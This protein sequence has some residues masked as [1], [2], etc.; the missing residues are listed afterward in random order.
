MKVKV[1]LI[2]DYPPPYGGISVHVKQL[3]DFLVEKGVERRVLD[4][5]PGTAPKEGAVRVTGYFSFLRRLVS[6]SFQGF[7]P[8]IH[9]NGHNFKSW[10][11]I[12]AAA[13]VGLLFG[14]R[15]VATVHSGLMPD[16][17]NQAG[18]PVR[19]TIRAA[20]LPLA[21]VIAVNE[22]IERALVDLEVDPK[23]ILVLPAFSLGRRSDSLPEPAR[24]WRERFQPLVVS[25][26]YLEKEYG[27]EFLIEACLHLKKKYPRLGCFIMGS[28]SEEAALRRRVRE[29][30]GEEWILL[31]GNVPHEACL[32]IMAKGDLFVRPA[33]FDGDAISVRE[34]L[35]LGVPT[36]ASNVGFRP[37]GTLLFEPGN[38]A[39]LVRQMER[40][41]RAGQESARAVPAE[42][43]KNLAF[44]HQAYE[45]A[46]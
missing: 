43:E 3:A 27:T 38:V 25:A 16:Y 1:L 18:L 17:V 13:W 5:E 22:K 9:T 12:G 39:D 42:R 11:A 33:L 20:L 44:I 46:V 40:G 14:R 41:L 23:Q 4:I 24:I 7:I 37:E 36:V 8:H 45:E 29:A 15:G 30:D 19:I 35:A 2:G 31:S 10:L 34:A 6:F 28:G 26:V 32:A 21:R